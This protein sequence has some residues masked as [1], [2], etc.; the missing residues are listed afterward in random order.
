MRLVLQREQILDVK[1]RQGAMFRV[2]AKLEL[3]DDEKAAIDRYKVEK[4]SWGEWSREDNI[5]ISRLVAGT[6]YESEFFGFVAQWER[7]VHDG[8][9][10]VARHVKAVSAYKGVATI[11]L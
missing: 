10:E 11:E 3:T 7:R 1:L 2:S 4:G 6:K 9:V 5:S 8:C